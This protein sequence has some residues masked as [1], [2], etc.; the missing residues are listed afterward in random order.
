MTANLMSALERAVTRPSLWLQTLTSTLVLL[1]D[2]VIPWQRCSDYS[3]ES[4]V[5]AQ[6][7]YG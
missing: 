3:C 6:V 5:A 7:N 2:P 1:L 4:D